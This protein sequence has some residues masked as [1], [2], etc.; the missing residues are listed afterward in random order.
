MADKN[1][2]I[3]NSDKLNQNEFTRAERISVIRILRSDGA[4]F[5]AISKVVGISR[6]RVHQLC[7]IYNIKKGKKNNGKL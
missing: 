7:K 3:G 2:L 5:S 1:E 4:A 6:Q